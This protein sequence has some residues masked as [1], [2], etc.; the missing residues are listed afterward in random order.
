MKLR[1]LLA[2]SA[3]A[4]ASLGATPAFAITDGDSPG[5]PFNFV[6][7]T[8]GGIS[9]D[10]RASVIPTVT[11]LRDSGCPD[12]ASGYGGSP[13]VAQNWAWTTDQRKQN[14]HDNGGADTMAYEHEAKFRTST[15]LHTQ[16]M[17]TNNIPYWYL[18]TQFE[19]SVYND[20]AGGSYNSIA[21]SANT[22]Y[23]D[24]IQMAWC[25]DARTRYI[26][27]QGYKVLVQRSYQNGYCGAGYEYCVTAK[28]GYPRDAV[29]YAEGYL[30]S[31]TL[32]ISHSYA[33]NRLTNSSFESGTSP[34]G[35]GFPYPSNTTAHTYTYG[36]YEGAQFERFGCTT[37]PCS[38]L[39]D[40]NNHI[41]V[42]GDRYTS[43]LVLRCALAANGSNC[44][45]SVY[46]R[47]LANTGVYGVRTYSI[48]QC[49]CWYVIEDYTTGWTQ[50]SAGLRLQIAPALTGD[51]VDVDQG[52]LHRTDSA[53]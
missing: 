13:R 6:V 49:T 52:L 20:I 33:T 38:M 51:L 15:D 2:A 32:A 18:D 11:E 26:P 34:S 35:W 44:G 17:I 40:D 19:D 42:T 24:N 50:T 7:P 9:F 41:I 37:G 25:D 39:Q 4:F 47:S 48:P 14:I 30:T 31:Q 27:Q 53:V 5:A 46:Q 43:G 3:V 22:V 12:P 29:P 23:S 36:G 21:L 1:S 28:P 45:V 8:S 16:M 10:P